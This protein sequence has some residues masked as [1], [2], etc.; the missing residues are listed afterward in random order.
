MAIT[1]QLLEPDS[2]WSPEQEAFIEWLALPKQD[3][4]PRTELALA[5][6]LGVDR[7]TLYR[8]R[9]LPE[10]LEEVRMLCLSMMG[11][12]LADVLASLEESALSSSLQHQRLYFEL[13]RM[14]G[15]HREIDP[16]P[17]WGLLKEYP[18]LDLSRVGRGDL[19]PDTKSPT[20]TSR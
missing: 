17:S 6:E 15:P 16:P 1:S 19:Y 13:L 4:I 10:L 12:R 7:T 11:P 5:K 2:D 20:D 3:R 9:K 18:G 14:I 8:W